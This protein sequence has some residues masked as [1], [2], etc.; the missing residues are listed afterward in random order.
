MRYELLLFEI[1]LQLSA[2]GVIALGITKFLT[3]IDKITPEPK[4]FRFL[5]RWPLGLMKFGAACIFVVPTA[6]YADVLRRDFD[7]PRFLPVLG[8]LVVA[9]VWHEAEK[10]IRKRLDKEPKE[11]TREEAQT[12]EKSSKEEKIPDPTFEFS[13][14]VS[15]EKIREGNTYVNIRI[16]LPLYIAENVERM[17]WGMVPLYAKYTLKDVLC[18]KTLDRAV[19]SEKDL[20][21]FQDQIDKDIHTLGDILERLIRI[22]RDPF[23]RNFYYIIPEKN[24]RMHLRSVVNG[25]DDL[26]RKYDTIFSDFRAEMDKI[27]SYLPEPVEGEGM[28]KLLDVPKDSFFFFVD[29]FCFGYDNPWKQSVFN[30]F[31]DRYVKTPLSYKKACNFDPAKI[32]DYFNED[33]R[34][35]V[36]YPEVLEDTPVYESLVQEKPYSIPL[37]KRFEHLVAFAGTG[38]GKTQMLQR[39]I[40]HT[41]TGFCVIDSQGDLINE[42]ARLQ[43]D[44]EVIL[45]DPSEVENTLA[46]SLFNV[47]LSGLDNKQK[48]AIVNNAVSSYSYLFEGIMEQNLTPR[49]RAMFSFVSKLLIEISGANIYTLQD[50]LENKGDFQPYIRR[51][52]LTT[53]RYFQNE[54]YSKKLGPVKEQVLD[55][56]YTVLSNDTF[57][58]LFAQTE[59]KFDIHQAMNQGQIVLISTAK[60]HMPDEYQ[61]YGKFWISQIALATMKREQIEPPKRTPFMIYID[62]IREY[63]DNPKYLEDLITQARKYRVGLNMFFQDVSQA[64]PLTD[65][66]L[67]NA[68][69]KVAGG[70]DDPGRLARAMHV[71]P[72]FISHTRKEEG[73]GAEFA[74]AVKGEK[75]KRVWLDFGALNDKPRRNPMEYEN[76]LAT[77]RARYGTPK[78]PEVEPPLENPPTPPALQK[79]EKRPEG[80]TVEADEFD[81]LFH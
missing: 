30:R 20:Y 3:F 55:R 76:F 28:F 63:M 69:I 71:T 16:T 37:S 40:E 54:F 4:K 34:R 24:D 25:V 60:S 41:D 23:E 73:R 7:L 51:M 9:F 81:D 5:K 50:I 64:G 14:V 70:L 79:K 43:F 21:E 68:S 72:E 12:T 42:L 52:N 36:V 38:H 35:G 6:Y 65:I 22:S 47:D 67:N 46:V 49:Q 18:N 33:W 29:L 53:Q 1:F 61:A 17:C 10:R 26:K 45:I 62:E 19:Q 8:F 58:R 11:E 15:R 39:L 75:T 48:Q 44:R 27:R 59:N 13:E 57:C 78:T 2:A 56:L 66:L 74:L 32:P 31:C 80:E 77:N